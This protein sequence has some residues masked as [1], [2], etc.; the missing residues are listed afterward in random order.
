M[1]EYDDYTITELID[2][3]TE[4]EAEKK[5]L[6]TA[7]KHHLK[8][9]KRLKTQLEAVKQ[10][11]RWTILGATKVTKNSEHPPFWVNAH[12]LAKIQ[13]KAIGEGE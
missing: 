12:E 3:I 1:S 5:S 13:N 4:L 9:N 7:A 11:E 8:E 2:R 6:F 10:L